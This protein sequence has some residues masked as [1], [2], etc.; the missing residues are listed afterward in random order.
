[1][2]VSHV[3]ELS[4]L[5]RIGKDDFGEQSPIDPA[6]GHDVRPAPSHLGER[7]ATGLES[8]M[9]HL[10]GVDRLHTGVGQVMAD[11]GLSGGETPTEYPPLPGRHKVRR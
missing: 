11:S 10:I 3:F 7:R 5:A 2:W 9:P 4:E 6:L 1:M 8:L